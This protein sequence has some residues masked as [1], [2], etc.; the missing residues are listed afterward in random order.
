MSDPQNMKVPV[1]PIE[2]WMLWVPSTGVWVVSVDDAPG[3]ETYLACCSEEEA[4]I[5]A[6]YQNGMY[7][8]LGCIPVRVK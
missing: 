5:A 1:V 7:D 2:L 8:Q 3:G 6:E 4:L